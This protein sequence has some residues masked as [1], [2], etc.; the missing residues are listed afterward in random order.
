MGDIF[1]NPSLIE[2]P[3]DRGSDTSAAAAKSIE[4]NAGTLRRI[5]YDAIV[6]GGPTGYT[7]A[8][9]QDSLGMR[10]QTQTARRV[11]LRDRG[12]IVDSG[13]RRPTPRG[14][15]AVVWVVAPRSS[16]G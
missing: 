13:F 4:P 9:L 16:N 1:S 2:A 8:E 6:A 14:R 11:E 7:D 5:V 15:D 3:F 10:A 12:L